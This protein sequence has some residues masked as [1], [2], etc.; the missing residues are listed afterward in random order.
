M[1]TR[2]QAAAV[3]TEKKKPVA[4]AAA[5]KPAVVKKPAAK[6]AARPAPKAAAPA[7]PAPAAAAAPKLEKKVEKADKPAKIEK[8][9]KVEKVEKAP[10]AKK[11][12]QVR[13]SFTMPENEYAVLAQ[14]K[15]SCLKA[16]VEIK[17]SDLLR[18]GV[19]L[20]K[21]LKIAELK[22]I[23]GSLTPLKVGRPKK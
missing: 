17:K 23:L 20:I 2:V 22:D 7:K 4:K 15:K 10:K 9:E 5:P 13:D 6:P 8:V 21:N 12:K 18:I 11:V 14:V 19:S 3:P 1:A 16:G